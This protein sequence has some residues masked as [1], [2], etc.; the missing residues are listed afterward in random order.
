MYSLSI[1]DIYLY[2]FITSYKNHIQ[3]ETFWSKALKQISKDKVCKDIMINI[4]ILRVMIT[5]FDMIPTKTLQM[6]IVEV[7]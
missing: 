7:N 1:L 2:I 3:I 4:L 5:L 6:I